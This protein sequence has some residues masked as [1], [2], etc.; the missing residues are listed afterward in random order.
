MEEHRVRGQAQGALALGPAQVL[1]GLV[2]EH[3]GEEHA[4]PAVADRAGRAAVVAAYAV[5]DVDHHSVP[6][7][8]RPPI[9]RS[10]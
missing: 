5:G 4:L 7:H 10:R 3:V 8:L 2:V 9:W 1:P 6:G